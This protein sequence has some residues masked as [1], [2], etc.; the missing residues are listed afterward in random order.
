MPVMPESEITSLIEFIERC[1]SYQKQ[2]TAGDILFFRGVNRIFPD[3]TRQVPSIYYPQYDF[4]ANEDI[5]FKD[6]LSQFPKEMLAQR[7]AVEQLI[8]MQHNGFPTRL[9]DI[10]KNPLI[11]LFFACYAEAL[12]D[13]SYS[14]DGIIFVYSIPRKEI[15]Y[16]DS[17]TVSI[18]ANLVKCPVSFNIK[19]CYNMKEDEFNWSA[20]IQYLLH[21]IQ[22]E[23]PSFKASIDPKDINRVVCLHPRMNNPRI[24]RQDG[25]FFLFGINGEK[26]SCASINPDWI[27]ESIIVSGEAKQRI[28]KELDLLNID[29]EF[30]FPDF[31][32]CSLYMKERYA[33]HLA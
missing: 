1:F 2:N 25:Y 19:N 17:D 12:D 33:R 9:L 30:V 32:H 24:I 5:I 14:E 10:S 3:E 23:K 27:R 6:V 28:I 31:A 20:P 4:I 7:T 22:G 11:S 16:C 21:E 15:K 18:I 26:A 13:Q 29:A 8:L